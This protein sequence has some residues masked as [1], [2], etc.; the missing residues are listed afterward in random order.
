MCQDLEL[1]LPPCLRIHAPTNA[2]ATTI[3]IRHSIQWKPFNNWEKTFTMPPK[4]ASSSATPELNAEAS[5][6][7]TAAADGSALPDAQWTAMQDILDYIYDYR[8]AEYGS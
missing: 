5:A 1:Y 2:N 3:T 8:I 4:R 7:A 6:A